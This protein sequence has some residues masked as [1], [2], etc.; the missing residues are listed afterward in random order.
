MLYHQRKKGDDMKRLISL[1]LALFL[2]M[3]C[4]FA[5]EP[6][7]YED[8]DSQYGMATGISSAWDEEYVD[9]ASIGGV[10]ELSVP[11]AI[12]MDV[13]TGTVLFE[14]NSSVQRP[15]ASVTK[16]MTLLLIMEA[17]DSGKLK[18]DDM[19]SC[20]EEAASMGG[21]QIWLE[22]GE[23]LSVSDML[24]CIT[25]AS[26]NDCCV[27]M[28][29]AI[30]GSHEG[31]VAM[32]NSRAKQLGMENTSFVNCTGLDVDGHVTT[33]N[34]IALMTREL[35]KHEKIFE[36]TTI[37]MDTVRD[38]KFGLANTN[39]LIRF[40]SGATGMKTGST[41][42]AKFCLSATAERNGLK[43]IAVVMAGETSD[44]RF[45][46][47]KKLLDYGFA[48]WAHA[49]DKETS[50]K[51]FE[52]PVEKGKNATVSAKLVGEAS[53]L[54]EKGANTS[55]EKEIKLAEKLQAPVA[56]GQ[57]VGEVV[58]KMD[59]KELG[60]IKI[61]TTAECERKGFFDYFAENIRKMLCA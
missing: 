36:Y 47:A 54:V 44:Q 23:Q 5:S 33:A 34:D 57:T 45:G 8:E 35:Y 49:D 50:E 42:K 58:Y 59:G 7:V 19:I 25:V 53:F 17:L 41:S 15:P 29:E 55:L 61:A 60:R 16:I 21:S 1:G 9:A 27:A 10:P 28:A 24:K 56:M 11:S 31:F 3:G 39:K 40:Y 30:A 20:S 26:A 22:P 6:P 37:W 51:V 38:G 18:L 43:L 12:L 48:N 13:S 2:M 14:K 46:D 52:I 4:V 32:M